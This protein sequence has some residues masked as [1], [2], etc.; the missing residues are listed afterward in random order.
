MVFFSKLE[1]VFR[2]KQNMKKTGSILLI[3]KSN[4]K[5]LDL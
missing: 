2:K 5:F 1:H 4:A 3:N